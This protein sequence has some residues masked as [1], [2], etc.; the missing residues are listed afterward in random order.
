MANSVAKKRVLESQFD[1]QRGTSPKENLGTMIVA[2]FSTGLGIFL[3]NLSP[4][5]GRFASAFFYLLGCVLVFLGTFGISSSISIYIVTRKPFFAIK[6]HKAL[7]YSVALS[8]FAINLGTLIVALVLSFMGITFFA[9][10]GTAAFAITDLV[11]S[12]V[13]FNIETE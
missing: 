7:F 10:I 12:F 1:T 8:W 3:L 4:D 13:L 9:P 11:L 6:L 5:L 2:A